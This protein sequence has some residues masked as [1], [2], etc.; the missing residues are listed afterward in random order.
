MGFYK[1][2]LLLSGFGMQGAAEARA[3][4]AGLIHLCPA[5]LAAVGSCAKPV[6]NALRSEDRC[7]FV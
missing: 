4:A 1:H 7:L 2:I 6:G 5:A 3:V